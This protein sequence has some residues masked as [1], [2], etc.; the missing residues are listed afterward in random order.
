M[1]INVLAR[2]RHLNITGVIDT[3]TSLDVTLRFNQV[4]SWTIGF[5]ATGDVRDL[6]TPGGGIVIVRDDD[7]LMSG[8]ARAH[9]VRVVGRRRDRR[10]R[11]PHPVRR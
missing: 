2:D 7:V 4:G 9:R 3:W 5:P 6:I 10:A 11:R 8:Q 1:A